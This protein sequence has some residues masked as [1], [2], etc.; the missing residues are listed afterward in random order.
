[1]CVIALVL[2]VMLTI[3]GASSKQVYYV[4]VRAQVTHDLQL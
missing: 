4:E 3:F 1:M 2:T